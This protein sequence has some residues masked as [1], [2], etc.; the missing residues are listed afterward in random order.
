MKTPLIRTENLGFSYSE[1][2]SSVLSDV[3]FSLNE[4]EWVAVV[5]ANGSGKSTFARELN[6]LL[7][8]TEGTVWVDGIDT[9]NEETVLEV[10]QRVGM[11][12][13]N[14]DNQLVATLVEEDVAFAP[15][16]LGVPVK[17][18]RCRVDEALEAVGM[19]E[20][21]NHSAH[22]L[23]GGQKQRVAIAGILAMRPR[24]IVLDEATAMLDPQGRKE[25][26]NTVRELQIRYKTA[27]VWITHFMD[28][29][30]FADRVLVFSKGRVLTEGTLR[31]VFEKTELL[32]EAGLK[33]PPAIALSEWLISQGYIKKQPIFTLEECA[34][35]LKKRLEGKPCR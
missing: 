19:S 11:V 13:Q 17:E 4:G 30:I 8:P 20:Y 2:S 25:V 29:V 24:C 22:Q 18:L 23:S 14:P 33:L 21:S 7:L 26:L 28:E 27:V 5:G 6:A 12:F 34:S 15:E 31:E 35:A 16:N 1:N 9:R 10:R 32:T 3:N